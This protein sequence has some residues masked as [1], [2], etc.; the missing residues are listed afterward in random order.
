MFTSSTTRSA[1]VHQFTKTDEQI[2]ALVGQKYDPY[3]LQS[4]EEGKLAVPT[5]PT[6]SRL[7]DGSIDE[8]EKMEYSKRYDKWLNLTYRIE[9]ELKQVYSFYLGQC[10]E[11]MKA[12]LSEDPD[13]KTINSKKDVL[14]LIKLLQ[15]INFNQTNSEEPI[16]SMFKAKSDFIR[17]RQ[18]KGQT[19]TEFYCHDGGEQ[20]PQHQHP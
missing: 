14:K 19:V 7:P 13:F 3:V 18:Q 9:V 5:K 17:L 4:L 6:Y 11:D 10:D 8:M 1:Q 2:K 12:S 16:V 15:S 20:N